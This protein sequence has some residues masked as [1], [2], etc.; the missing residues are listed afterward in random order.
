M[1]APNGTRGDAPDLLTA[2]MFIG[3]GA[4]GLYMARGLDG[5]TL[6]QMGPGFLPRTV[7][8]LL[9][10]IGLAVGLPA[11]TRPAQAIEAIR[12]RPLAVITISIVGFAFAA[13]YLGFVLASLW[14]V[15]VG[16]LADPGGKWS[17][18]LLLAAGLTL[19]GALVF[20]YGLGVQVPLWPV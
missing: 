2:G 8:I 7:C 14:L 1:A 5:G 6:A 17:H 12:I 18:I 3:L 4:L 9:I 11:L 16:S 10:L 20:V 19:F 13:T 15:I